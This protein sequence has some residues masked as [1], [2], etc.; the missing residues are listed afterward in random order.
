MKKAE[1]HGSWLAAILACSLLAGQSACA[2]TPAADQPLTDVVAA[3]VTPLTPP[4]PARIS[5]ALL[6]EGEQRSLVVRTCALCH[7]IELV[8]QRK[9]SADEWDTQIAKMVG[10]GAKATDTEQE[11]IFQYLVK[12]FRTDAPA[13]Q[14]SPA[15][16]P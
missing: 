2:A 13:P 4:D 15:I 10:Y 8:V 3:S 9:R 11:Q 16:A 12:N 1:P 14:S 5:A 6:P 7:A